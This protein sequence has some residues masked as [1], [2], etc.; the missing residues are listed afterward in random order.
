MSIKQSG[1]GHESGDPN[2]CERLARGFRV[3]RRGVCLSGRSSFLY[4]LKIIIFNLKPS[5]S[6]QDLLMLEQYYKP[7]ENAVLF[8]LYELLCDNHQKQNVTYLDIATWFNN[9]Q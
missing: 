9:M 4:F 6:T 8:A 2:T 7:E 3:N 1:R 5:M